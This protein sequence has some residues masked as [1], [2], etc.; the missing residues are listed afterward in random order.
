M[1]RFASSGWIVSSV[2]PCAN[3]LPCQ[4]NLLRSAPWTT[5]GSI[6]A[7]VEIKNDFLV[8]CPR[9]QIPE[10]WPVSVSRLLLKM[11]PLPICRL[12]RLSV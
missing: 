2:K 8:G 4:W 1:V 12:L 10:S 5:Y 11:N 3:R 7:E 6:A 9:C